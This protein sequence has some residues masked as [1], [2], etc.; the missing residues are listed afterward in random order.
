MNNIQKIAKFLISAN[1]YEEACVLFDVPDNVKKNICEIANKIPKSVINIEAGGLEDKAHVT[2]IY[3][4][5]DTLNLKKYFTKSLKIRTDNKITYFDNDDFSVA[6]IE[7]FSDDLKKLHYAIKENEE[8]EHKYDYSPHITI[9]FLQKGKRLNDI[10]LDS[11]EWEQ[12]EINLEKNG[13][14]DRIRIN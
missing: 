9:A 3:G 8:N 4:V 1:F 10:K 12:K 2:I 14:I 6:K 5:N 13:L 11:F 7:V